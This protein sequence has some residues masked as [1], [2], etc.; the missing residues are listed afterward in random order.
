[1]N[2]SSIKST[3]SAKKIDFSTYK[4]PKIAVVGLGYVGLPLC[5]ALAKLFQT[6]GFDISSKKITQLKQNIDPIDELEPSDL[7][8]TQAAFTSEIS[9]LKESTIKILTVPTPIDANKRPDLSLVKSATE[10]IATVLKE[11]DIVVYEST[12]YP[13]VTEDVCVPIL[14]KVSG[15]TFNKDFFVGYSPER[16]SP[17]DKNRSLQKIVKVVS[18]STPEVCDILADVYGQVIPAGIY[19]A[20]S[21]K[22]AEAAKVVENV[23]RDLNV[24]LMNELSIL[25]SKIGIDT[26]DVINAAATKWNF[27]KMSPG[28]VGGHC[29]GV[30]PYYLTHKAE[31]LGYHP[32]VIL[33]GRRIN[34]SMG[35]YVAEQVVKLLIKADKRVKGAR[36]GILGMTFKENVSDIRNSKVKD[37]IDELESYACNVL[38]SDDYAK[39]EEVSEEYSFDLVGFDALNELDALIVAVPHSSYESLVFEDLCQKIT[40]VPV[41]FDIKGVFKEACLNQET[42]LGYYQVL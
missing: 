21:I 34:D 35:K 19:K 29:I 37:V 3:L 31:L 6:Q 7:E 42:V 27:M 18:G 28:L 11:G 12:V 33:S 36:V 16:L 8:D 22:V 23:Q 2:D 5:I 10:S 4:N 30:D 13:G 1:M 15:L 20:K 24:A 9:E 40:G 14:E 32:Q 25:F 26:M 38:V 39:P 17:G 41:V